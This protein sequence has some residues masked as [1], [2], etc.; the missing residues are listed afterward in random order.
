MGVLTINARNAV[1]LHAHSKLLDRVLSCQRNVV[2]EAF[3]RVEDIRL[4]EIEGAGLDNKQHRLD[5]GANVRA[6]QLRRKN[7]HPTSRS[8]HQ[9][10]L[11][12]S[13]TVA[14][15]ARAS[16]KAWIGTTG[17]GLSR[18]CRRSWISFILSLVAATRSSCDIEAQI[19]ESSVA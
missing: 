16:L 3:V 7:E 9:R 5:T 6:L 11:T 15:V 14:M 17:I 8:T 2:G 4:S 10:E 13:S 1:S 12:L 18:A 19:A